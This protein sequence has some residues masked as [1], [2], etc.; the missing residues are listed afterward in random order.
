MKKNGFTLVEVVMT[1]VLIGIAGL[2]SILAIN[3]YMQQSY[4][5]QIKIIRKTIESATDNYRI[6]NNMRPSYKMPLSELKGNEVYLDN[7][8][9]RKGVVCAIDSS[10]G[11]VELVGRTGHELSTKNESYCIKFYCNGELIIDDYSQDSPNYNVC[12]G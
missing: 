6:S 1:M 11:T 12:G 2:V 9:Y 8:N 3:R 4:N 7:I 10:A 5:E